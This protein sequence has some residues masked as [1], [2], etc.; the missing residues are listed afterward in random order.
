MQENVQNQILAKKK[1]EKER[2]ADVAAQE[3]Y[4]RMED[5]K[6][7]DRRAEVEAREKRAQDFMNRMADGVLKDMDEMQRK[8]DEMILRYEREREV[9]ERQKEE[10]KKRKRREIQAEINKTLAK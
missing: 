9:K 6:A 1:K 2:L 4:I 7:A 10:E 5:Q 8:E 3:A